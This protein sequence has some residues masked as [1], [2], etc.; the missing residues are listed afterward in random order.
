MESQT[1]YKKTILPKLKEKF[2]YKNDLEAPRLKKVVV[3]VGFGRH[4]K[5][6]AYIDAV[7]SGLTRITGQKPVLAKARKSISSFK[8]REGNVIGAYVTLR[9]ARM[10]DFVNKLIN[11]TFPR[12]RDFRGINEKN[13]DRM[14]N[15]T[16]G[17]REHISFPEISADEVENVFGLEISLSI[18]ARSREEGLELYKLLGFPIKKDK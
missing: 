17:F 10:H 13:V 1:A 18:G 12:V 16:I 7:V 2:G 4:M 8:I 15:M 5:E 11:I 14:G 9:G 6:K 3:N